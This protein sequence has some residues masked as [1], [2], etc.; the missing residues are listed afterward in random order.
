M[1]NKKTLTAL[2]FSMFTDLALADELDVLALKSQQQATDLFL[3][4]EAK[5]QNTPVL[6]IK[7]ADCLGTILPD[8]PKQPNFTTTYAWLDGNS[9]SLTF[10]R[11]TCK[12]GKDKVLLF[13]ATPKVGTP[14]ICTSSFKVVQ[15]DNQ[16]GVWFVDG[17]GKHFCENLIVSKTF[18]F[19]EY[20]GELF[21][22]AAALTL[23]ADSKK[24]LNIP[25][26]GIIKPAV[27]SISGA[28]N[29]YTNFS[30]TCKN[31]STGAIKSFPPQT[32]PAFNCTGLV[33]KKG[34]K[35]QTTIT[36]VVK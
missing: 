1:K 10:W 2:A 14:F 29:G 23:Y 12:N 5:A 18:V 6:K 31:I 34:Q 13:R 3:L 22:P 7:P 30:H 25:L 19:D 11:E 24:L 36:G 21:N 9:A 32:V 28:V 15:N 33:M 16:Y 20:P 26:K 8:A 35:I 17:A 27:T 4:S